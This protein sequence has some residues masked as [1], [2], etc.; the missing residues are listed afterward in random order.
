MPKTVKMSHDY[1]CSADQLWPIVIDYAYLAEVMQGKVSF[2][3]MPDGVTETG[4]KIHVKTSLFGKLPE[5]DYY[6]EILECNHETMTVHSSERGSGVKSWR[7]RFKVI[8]TETGCRLTDEIE[9]D[10]GLMTWLFCLWAGY[11]YKG[12][13]A[14][15]L[16]ILKR[17][18]G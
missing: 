4:Q 16:R 13:H 7:H 15:R 3:G 11:M 10:A 2:T 1:A 18:Y 6:M 14:P 5:Q 12:R 9:I 8:Q 17:L